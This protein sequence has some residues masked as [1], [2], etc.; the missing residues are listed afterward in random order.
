[1]I[2]DLNRSRRHVGV[3]NLP[4]SHL[5]V[6]PGIQVNTELLYSAYENFLKRCT[7]KSSMQHACLCRYVRI[8]VP[9]PGIADVREE[10]YVYLFRGCHLCRAAVSI[11]RFI[12]TS[13][14]LAVTWSRSGTTAYT[15]SSWSLHRYINSHSYPILFNTLLLSSVS[16][17]LLFT[18]SCSSRDSL[19]M[20]MTTSEHC[21]VDDLSP[22]SS[23]S[24]S[25]SL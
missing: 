19:W 13:A 4:I 10:M 8:A 15:M 7:F 23:N 1:M 3:T 21:T 6:G 17:S 5:Q 11:T 20:T 9:R 12:W 16:P 2:C 18:P 25:A 14:Q 22:T 24:W